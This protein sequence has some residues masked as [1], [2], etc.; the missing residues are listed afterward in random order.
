MSDFFFSILIY[1]NITKLCIWLTVWLLYLRLSFYFAN[2]KNPFGLLVKNLVK[3]FLKEIILQEEAKSLSEQRGKLLAWLRGECRRIAPP[4]SENGPARPSGSFTLISKPFATSSRKLTVSLVWGMG[5]NTQL[6][7]CKD[8][9][10][11]EIV[12]C[13]GLHF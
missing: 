2:V 13:W 6:H 1:S 4:W 11:S 5:L 8:I 9:F 7:L 12:K 10:L 3:Y